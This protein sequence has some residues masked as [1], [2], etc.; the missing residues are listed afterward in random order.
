MFIG[1]VWRRLDRK[2]AF[3]VVTERAIVEVCGTY[4]KETIVKDRHLGVDD[5]HLT[6]WCMW[7]IGM[8]AAK[9]VDLAEPNNEGVACA[10]HHEGVAEAGA[11]ARTHNH[12]LGAVRLGQACR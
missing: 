9:A 12:D 10:I 1:L 4:T 8:K 5:H 3:G 7:S 6:T 11:P 2:I